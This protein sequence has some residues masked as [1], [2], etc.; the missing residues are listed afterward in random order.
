MNCTASAATNPFVSSLATITNDWPFFSKLYRPSEVKCPSRSG[1]TVWSTSMVFSPSALKTVTW[2]ASARRTFRW[3]RLEQARLLAAANTA[4][5][6]RAATERATPR[7][8][9][10]AGWLPR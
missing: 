10:R 4:V 7:Y 2:T 1:G 5:A 6:R 8:R 9:P 3:E